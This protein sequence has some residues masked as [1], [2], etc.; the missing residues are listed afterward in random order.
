MKRLLIIGVGYVGME[1]LR[2]LR[3]KSYEISLTTTCKERVEELKKYSKRVLLLQPQGKDELE[4]WIE[5]SDVLIIL[6][7]PNDSKSYEETYLNTAKRVC[8]AIKDR[9]KPLYL[10]YTSSTS[11]CEGAGDNP[12]T[13]MTTL[14]P[15]SENGK[16]LLETEHVYLNSNANSCILR[17]G[18][19]Y[20]PKREWVDRARRF[21]GLMA[22][23]NGDKPTNS[24]HLDDIVSAIVFCFENTL[25]GIYHLVNDDHR[26]RRDLYDILCSSLSL[27]GPLW[28]TGPFPSSERGYK[29][30]NQKIKDAG[31]VF[32]HQQVLLMSPLEHH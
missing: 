8:A 19:I 30:C 18:G 15:S 12:V 28:S 7:A 29:V 10:L 1:L 20:G 24:I 25:K 17:L 22:Q 14:N 16:I 13:E 26:S 9:E 27:P 21:S 4:Q 11:V 5:E 31:F 3:E 23:G 6:V 2:Q 32:K